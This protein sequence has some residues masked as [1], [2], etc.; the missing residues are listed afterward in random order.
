MP[1]GYL[2]DGQEALQPKGAQLAPKTT[3]LYPAPRLREGG[4]TGGLSELQLTGWALRAS[5]LSL[6]PLDALRQQQGWAGWVHQPGSPGRG[7]AGMLCP[8]AQSEQRFRSCPSHRLDEA[9]LGAVDPADAALQRLDHAPGRGA[10]QGPGSQR[11]VRRGRGHALERSPAAAAGTQQKGLIN[12]VLLTQPDPSP[13]ALLL[14]PLSLA[15]LLV[16][17][18]DARPQPKLGGIGQLDRLRLAGKG[19]GRQHGAE[20]LGRG[21]GREVGMRE[22]AGPGNALW[23]HM[24]QHGEYREEG[25]QQASSRTFHLGAAA[26]AHQPNPSPPPSRCA[27]AAPH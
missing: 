9:G 21:V 22:V 11:T 15:A 19:A 14:S 16:C 23:Q 26:A 6:A 27:C 8:P 12:P 3:V 1:R 17:R 4:R 25:K 20:D 13:S 2:L 24:N 7:A 18:D 5:A 10:G